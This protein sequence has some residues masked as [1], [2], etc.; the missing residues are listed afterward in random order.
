VKESAKRYKMTPRM[1]ELAKPRDRAA[2]GPNPWAF[3]VNPQ[4]LKYKIT[5]RMIELAQPKKDPMFAKHNC[6]RVVK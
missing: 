1:E 3:Q 4:A 5:P 6:F 2:P